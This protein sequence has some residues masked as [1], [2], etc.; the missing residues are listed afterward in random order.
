MTTSTHFVYKAKNDRLRTRCYP[1]STSFLEIINNMDYISHEIIK[2]TLRSGEV[3]AVDITGA[4]YGYHEPVTPWTKYEQ[5]RIFCAISAVDPYPSSKLLQI[6]DYNLQ[7]LKYFYKLAE[8]PKPHVFMTALAIM[9]WHILGWQ[10]HENMSLKK[11]WA[12]PEETLR[13]KLNDLIHFIEWSFRSPIEI[14]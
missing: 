12:L 10:K 5:E 6:D 13:M 1:L 7:E 9:K 3:F 8:G 2:V 11:W 4:Q 14:L